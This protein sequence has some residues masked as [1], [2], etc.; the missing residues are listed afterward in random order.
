[1]RSETTTAQTSRLG[2][3]AIAAIVFAVGLALGNLAPARAQTDDAAQNAASDPG[4]DAQSAQPDQQAHDAADAAEEALDTATDARNQ[5][6]SDGAP[7]D[8][9]DAANQAVTEA[10]AAK[11]A[12]DQA[13]QRADDAQNN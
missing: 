9:I 8:Q 12:A 13:A 11:D 5:L 3:V 10:R 1:M 4:Q 6:E 2:W 7:Q